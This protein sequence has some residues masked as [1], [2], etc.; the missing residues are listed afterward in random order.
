MRER[1]DIL[2]LESFGGFY[3]SRRSRDT[4]ALPVE[5]A[6][7]LLE[8]TRRPAAQVL[9][10]D[11]SHFAVI[12]RRGKRTL[13]EWQRDGLLDAEGLCHARIVANRPPTGV[14]GAPLATSFELTERCNLSCQHCYVERC[15]PG[16]AEVSP[17]TL[18]LAFAALARAGSPGI[19][20]SG[21]EP[22]ARQDLW[23]ILDRARDQQMDIKFC[24]NGTLVDRPC[25]RRL[26][27]YPI[28]TFSISL[29]GATPEIHDSVRGAG[30]FEQVARGV[31]H[32]RAAGAARILLRLTVNAR[33]L[34]TLADVAAVGD[35]WGVD[36]VS[37]R[38]FRYNGAALDA[39]LVV[40]RQTYDLA[41]RRLRRR[42]RGQ[43]KGIF[44]SSL[45]ARAPRFAGYIP[46]FGC[47]GGH[48]T[49]SVKAD[50]SVVA[51]ASVRAPDEWKLAQHDLIE[52]WYE[53]PSIR[54]WRSLEAPGEC[55]SCAH[56]DRCGGGCRA[57]AQALGLGI[58]G[59][60]TWC[61]MATEGE[62]DRRRH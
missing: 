58:E 27:R 1:S 32:L 3:Y 17:A 61:C 62:G 30:N 7:L 20:L 9:R 51:C 21:G 35:A 26:V 5:Y 60:D 42:W 12:R 50:G 56:L 40:N 11:R 36:A 53:A 38:P 31:R 10:E 8:A 55:A 43:C 46:R 13:Q 59:V 33:N 2:R 16:S 48:G 25:A 45:P 41:L 4:T 47:N 52:A 6:D 18:G 29:D 19:T 39:S 49:L 57:R 24:T 37:F 15:T 34:G 23:E 54:R 14:L 22:L 28:H 44:G